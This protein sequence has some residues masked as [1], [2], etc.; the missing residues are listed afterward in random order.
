[1]TQTK[2][3]VDL[4]HRAKIE[5]AK[6][7]ATHMLSSDTLTLRSG[8][9]LINRTEYRTLVGALQYL[10]LIRPD[11]A[12]VVNRLSQFMHQP[13]NTHWKAVKSVLRY[14]AG[15]IDK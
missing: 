14:M 6:P 13:T 7:T 9:K 4:L 12:F 2:Y 5:N 3:I 10:G 11:I 15:T 1:M 8:D